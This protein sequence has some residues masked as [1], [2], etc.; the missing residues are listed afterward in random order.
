MTCCAK[1]VGSAATFADPALW[2]SKIHQSDKLA[3]QFIEPIGEVLRICTPIWQTGDFF[4]F[5]TPSAAE[6][7]G[8]EIH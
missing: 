6:P 5:S 8:D 7:L 2:A 4:I 1:I 3:L